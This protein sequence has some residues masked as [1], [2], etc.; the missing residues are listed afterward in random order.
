MLQLK[1]FSSDDFVSFKFSIINS[2][3]KVM[4]KEMKCSTIYSAK[5]NESSKLNHLRA[6]V[7][8]EV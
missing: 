4:E 1:L 7:N 8:K 5:T 2:C 3:N 6:G